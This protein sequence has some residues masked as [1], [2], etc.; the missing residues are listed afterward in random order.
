MDLS[1]LTKRRSIWVSECVHSSLNTNILSYQ[2]F[3][4]SGDHISLE[5]GVLMSFLNDDNSGIHV[6]V[7]SFPKLQIQRP[8]QMRL[9]MI[10]RSSGHSCI[11]HLERRFLYLLIILAQA[12]GVS[13][14]SLSRSKL[15]MGP[16]M[17][18]SMKK[19][20]RKKRREAPMI[21][22]R[23]SCFSRARLFRYCILPSSYNYLP[24]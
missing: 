6:T 13:T 21:V 18:R 7:S 9:Y 11:Y 5:F 16:G 14:P 10:A 3:L 1:R 15:L 4:Q 17:N 20:D 2:I 19:Y 23:R 24:E 22:Y 12:D 8:K